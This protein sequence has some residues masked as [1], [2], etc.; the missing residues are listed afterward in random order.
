MIVIV[1]CTSEQSLRKFDSRLNERAGRLQ[2]DRFEVA[3]LGF[4]QA[5]SALLATGLYAR[6]DALTIDLR[7]CNFKVLTNFC[8][9]RE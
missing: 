5:V 1:L 2:Q 7:H 3:V 9:V 6:V 8:C 4:I